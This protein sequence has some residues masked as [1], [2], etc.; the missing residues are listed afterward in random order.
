MTKSE[1]TTSETTVAQTKASSEADKG[2]PK[3]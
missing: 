1:E 3:T 2:Q